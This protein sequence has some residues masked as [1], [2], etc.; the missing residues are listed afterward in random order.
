MADEGFGR[1]RWARDGR[2][3]PAGDDD[4]SEAPAAPEP[5]A[6]TGAARGSVLLPRPLRR[7]LGMALL[8]WWV[9]TLLSDVLATPALAPATS[10]AGAHL[11]GALSCVVAACALVALMVRL[12]PLAYRRETGL[13]VAAAGAVGGILLG[14]AG[15]ALPA[16]A[17]PVGSCLAGVAAAW[18][19]VAWQEYVATLPLRRA[20]CCLAL[21]ALLGTAAFLLCAPLP[22]AGWLALA[23]VLPVASQV[24]LRPA[25]GTRFYASDP[26][27]GHT[28]TRQVV[29]LIARDHSPRML[30]MLALVAFAAG[31][32]CTAGIGAGL[33]A[34]AAF[35]VM[36]PGG[37]AVACAALMVTPRALLSRSLF[38]SVVLATAGVVAC[39]WRTGV[40][41]ILGVSLLFLATGSAYA[42]IMIEMMQSARVRRLPMTGLLASLLAALLLGLSAGQLGARLCLPA[43][44]E[45]LSLAAM[46]ALVAAS[47][48]LGSMANRLTVSEELLAAPERTEREERVLRLATRCELTPRETQ[49]L[50][51]WVEGHN[52]A[53]VEEALHISRNTVKSHLNHIYQKTKVTSR[54][55]LLALLER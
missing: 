52:A 47:L 50:Q 30:A 53:Y 39:V 46:C 9:L 20:L 32:L 15:G 38:V 23:A 48:L 27:V 21:A 55:E 37:V 12:A 17:A 1:V 36:L 43:G 28:S 3:R 45:A 49:I 33:L 14:S 18:Q 19:L 10:L 7:Y 26:Q 41:T 40:S 35:A 16:G 5:A 42:M 8:A 24:S 2:G 25:R 29:A 44:G 13:A 31:S 22:H 54:E 11:A 6:G 4:A 34:P 51:I